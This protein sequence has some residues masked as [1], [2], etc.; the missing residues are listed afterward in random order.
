MFCRKQE[1]VHVNANH[2]DSV[3]F[4]VPDEDAWVRVDC[5]ESEA[6]EEGN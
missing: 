4:F 5:S 3:L 6:Y 2:G 1:V